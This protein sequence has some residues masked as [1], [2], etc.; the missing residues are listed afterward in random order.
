MRRLQRVGVLDGSCEVVHSR[1]RKR[2]TGVLRFVALLACCI[3]PGKLL[4]QESTQGLPEDITA[5]LNAPRPNLLPPVL[6]FPV[7]AEDNTV[8]A[9]G[10][11]LS[12][13]AMFSATYGPERRMA[14]NAPFTLN[15]L[16]ESRCCQE[17]VTL[18]DELIKQTRAACDNPRYVIPRLTRNGDEFSLDLEIYDTEGKS[19]GFKYSIREQDYGLIP[20][21]IAQ[22]V[23]EY[24]GGQLTP[25]QLQQL[26]KPQVGLPKKEASPVSWPTQT[27]IESDAW[28]RSYLAKYPGCLLA[29][30]TSL[31]R[32]SNV[33]RAIEHFESQQP[34]IPFDRLEVSAAA[35]LRDMGLPVQAVRRLLKVLPTHADDTYFWATF[36]GC[37]IAM[38][39]DNLTHRVLAEWRKSCNKYSD[40]LYRGIRYIDWAWSARGG[41]WAYEVDPQDM[42]L[43]HERLEKARQ[44]LEAAAA[45][46]RLGWAAHAQL[47]VVAM[48]LGLPRSY[49]ESHFQQALQLPHYKFAYQAK[50]EY[51]K[52]RWH[53]SPQE[54]MSFGRECVDTRLWDC[55]IPQLVVEAID[56]VYSSEEISRSDE[57]WRELVHYKDQALLHGNEQQQR[58]AL[59]YLSNIS[60]RAG[61]QETQELLDRIA[62]IDKNKPD[63]KEVDLDLVNVLHEQDHID[64]YGERLPAASQLRIAISEGRLDTATQI[65]DSMKPNSFAESSLTQHYRRVVQ[66]GRQLEEHGEVTLEPRHLK[67]AFDAI[68]D[69]Q[70]TAYSYGELRGEEYVWQYDP[71][72]FTQLYLVSPVPLAVGTLSGSLSWRPG[73]ALVEVG[74]RQR[75]S[76]APVYLRYYPD[77]SELIVVEDGETLQQEKVNI[78]HLEFAITIGS[79]RT[80]ITVNHDT[81]WEILTDSPVAGTFSVRAVALEQQGTRKFTTFSVREL[82][83][84]NR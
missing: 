74:W 48:G 27:S 73:M 61:K 52:P 23:V 35:R 40:H 18:S 54:L 6:I 66:W 10:A 82:R 70:L 77:K 33:R 56:D 68:I 57:L 2:I 8:R 58:A 31:T 1:K 3:T 65:L 38:E 79:N 69:G 80:S 26:K 50:L 43:F 63:D 12:F 42:R 81:Q 64:A 41:G 62:A 32:A 37:A 75:T 71:G 67:H 16:L 29:W 30:E 45:K 4:A 78:D 51:L 22:T 84:T 72:D 34:D 7:V 59:T 28:F 25:R 17:G 47:I 60:T 39:D 15:T 76:Q 49:M 46:N 44:E 55:G 20:G 53:G 83:V 5:A 36:V 24:V 19:S 21:R 9:D 11:M 14:T 13:M